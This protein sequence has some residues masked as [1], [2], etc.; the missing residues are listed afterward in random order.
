ML[1]S[2]RAFCIEKSENREEKKV[3]LP[4]FKNSNESEDEVTFNHVQVAWSRAHIK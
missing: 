2:A 4:L 3:L 1:H